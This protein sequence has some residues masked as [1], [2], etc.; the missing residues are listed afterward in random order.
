MDVCDEKGWEWKVEMLT[1]ELLEMLGRSKKRTLKRES[2]GCHFSDLGA[3]SWCFGYSRSLR[4][5]SSTFLVNGWMRGNGTW[6]LIDD[7]PT[8]Q[9]GYSSNRQ[10]KV[11]NPFFQW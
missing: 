4:S 6:L 8:S 7:S 5:G 3:R 10:L 11:C 1:L 9:E 2:V